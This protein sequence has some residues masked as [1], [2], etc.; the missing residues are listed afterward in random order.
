MMIFL[1]K[2]GLPFATR[3]K[4]KHQHYQLS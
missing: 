4:S 1:H 2:T 3:T